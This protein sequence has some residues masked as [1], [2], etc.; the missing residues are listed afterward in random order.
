MNTNPRDIANESAHQWATG[1]RVTWPTEQALAE[2]TAVDMASDMLGDPRGRPY[3]GHPDLKALRSD[4]RESLTRLSA[5]L[6]AEAFA[7]VD[8]E[9]ALAKRGGDA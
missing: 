9:R 2:A 5:A 6:Y 8:A 7:R 1:L 4:A 3:A